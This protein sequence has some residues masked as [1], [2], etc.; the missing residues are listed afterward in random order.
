MGAWE[1]N[2]LMLTKFW[3]TLSKNTGDFQC[4][5][6]IRIHYCNDSCSLDCG[7]FFF[8]SNCAWLLGREII[9]SQ[10]EGFPGR[11]ILKKA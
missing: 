3:E 7:G 9:W 1:P 8:F 5:S 11:E 2:V 6:E 4:P 10:V